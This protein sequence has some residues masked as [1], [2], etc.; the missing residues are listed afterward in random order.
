LEQPVRPLSLQEQL[1]VSTLLVR[2]ALLVKEPKT[3]PPGHL[4]WMSR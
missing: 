1:A 4:H 2:L 3:L